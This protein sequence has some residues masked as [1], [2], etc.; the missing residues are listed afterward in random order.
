MSDSRAQRT[1]VDARSL[2]R[3]PR[4]I[5]MRHDGTRGRWL[6]LAPERVFTPDAV[7]VAVLK[8]CDGSRSV[9][10]IAAELA[11]AYDAPCE[12]ILADIVPMLQ[13]LADKG[14]VTA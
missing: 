12:R 13:D 5:K 3:L 7:A 4:H 8:L 14:V 11:R 10:A 1:I 9:E 6:I 2:P